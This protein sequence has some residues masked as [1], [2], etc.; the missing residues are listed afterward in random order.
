[1]ADMRP[2]P[3]GGSR[4]GGPRPRGGQV[5]AGLSPERPS[6][7]AERTSRCVPTSCQE[8]VWRNQV[9]AING[10]SVH[11]KDPPAGHCTPDRKSRRQP[12][13]Q[14]AEKLRS[15]WSP[16]NSDAG[17]CRELPSPPRRERGVHNRARSARDRT[18]SSQAG[19][20]TLSR[21]SSLS[22]RATDIGPRAGGGSGNR[23]QGYRFEVLAGLSRAR[24]LLWT[25][26]CA[27]RPRGVR[28]RAGPP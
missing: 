17:P 9:Q 24:T 20:G 10:L 12:L 23:F 27:R 28:A 21:P 8:P 4:Q 16:G 1:M 2:D 6:T 25:P 26:P 14:R 7:S 13:T 5:G 15:S 11:E 3:C 22:A 18:A 19:S